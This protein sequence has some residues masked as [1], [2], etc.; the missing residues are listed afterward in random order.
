MSLK[1]DEENIKRIRVCRDDLWHESIATFKNP[2]FDCT[3]I[4]NVKF[5]GEAGSDAGGLRREYGSLLCKEIFSGQANL[6]EGTEERKLPIYSID[7]IY[8][9]LFHL[10]GKIVAYLVN[11]I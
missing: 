7:S 3:A 5:E 2:Q 6:F 1:L 4:P 11:I 8:S 10:A 9:R